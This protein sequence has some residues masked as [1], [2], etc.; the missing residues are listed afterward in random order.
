MA[1]NFK[2]FPGR[3]RLVSDIPSGDGKTANIFLQCRKNI[4]KRILLELSML[5]DRLR[6]ASESIVQR[7][8]HTEAS[9]QRL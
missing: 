5:I 4:G 8:P 3:G 1:P 2:L 7:I 6:L 9:D